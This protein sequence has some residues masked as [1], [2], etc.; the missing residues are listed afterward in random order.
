LGSLLARRGLST[1]RAD[2]GGYGPDLP[3]HAAA[4][5]LVCEAI[6]A[7][8][9][10][11]GEDMGLAIDVAATH[12][13]DVDRGVYE[14]HSEGVRT[15]DAAGLVELLADW[16]ARYP[17]V[18]IED[19]LSEDDWDGWTLV[20]SRLGDTVQLLGDDLFATNLV[21]LERGIADGAGNAVLV[22]MNQAGTLTETLAVI[23][24][25]HTAGV[26]TVVSARSGE[27]EDPFVADLA[28]ATRGGQCKIGSVT[29]SERLAKYNQ[30]LRIEGDLEEG[31]AYA[32]RSALPR[33]RA[34]RDATL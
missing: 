33:W 17:I 31:A 2:E 22:K 3:D 18:S 23:R 9:L 21:R 19:P 13:Y 30:L 27:T 8:G 16:C 12:F 4:L 14:L 15:V 29:Q 32:G 24:R 20:T 6:E 26:A 5:D 7:S 1:L 10:T 11:P 34:A 28:V 25:A